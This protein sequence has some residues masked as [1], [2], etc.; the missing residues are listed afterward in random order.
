MIQSKSGYI[1]LHSLLFFL[2]VLFMVQPHCY[3]YSVVYSSAEYTQILQGH[4]PFIL[5]T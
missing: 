1:Y 3:K 5:Y 2:Y 4:E